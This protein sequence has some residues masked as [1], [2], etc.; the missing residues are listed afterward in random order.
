[1][2]EFECL[3]CGGHMEIGVPGREN[4]PTVTRRARQPTMP[5][6]WGTIKPFTYLWY[7]FSTDTTGIKIA[8]ALGVP[9]GEDAPSAD[10]KYV[11][12]WG[13]KRPD[14]WR[15]ADGVTYI[16][17]PSDIVFN[18]NK[19][20][21]LNK[22]RDDGVRVP[23]T[24]ED[25]VPPTAL[26][27]LGRRTSHQGGEDAIMCMQNL[28]IADARENGSQYFIQYIRKSAEYRI[29]VMNGVVHMASKKLAPRGGDGNNMSRI[30]W[31]GTNGWRF[32]NSRLNQVPQDVK[33]IS[34]AAVEAVGLHFGAVDVIIGEDNVPYVLE[35]NT[36]PSLRDR[37]VE[38][39]AD[40][41]RAH[42]VANVGGA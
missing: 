18:R 4:V 39:Y 24:Y 17:K 19:L 12:C 23:L 36:G 30:I 20:R 32:E 34:V 13:N 22:M 28:D 31:S 5:Q 6:T 7:S 9:H 21:A 10:M 15:E 40:K 41:F 38:E 3:H 33:D 2:V 25:I 1:M 14:G 26:P 8:E 29:H 11:I 16:N 27:V 42:G 37:R 35:V